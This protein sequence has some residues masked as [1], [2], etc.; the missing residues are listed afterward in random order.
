MKI[1]PTFINCSSN[2]IF[3]LLS[4]LAVAF[5]S[6]NSAN[7]TNEVAAV[8]SAQ[9]TNARKNVK[10]PDFDSDSAYAFTKKQVD[11]GPRVP[12]TSAHAKCADYLANKL[13]TYGL[14]VQVQHATIKTYDGKQFDMKN[15]IGS[16][17]PN[18]SHRIF[19]S[20]HWD[21]RPFADD[22]TVERDK[23]IDAAIDGASGVAVA[24][25]VARNLAQGHPEIGVD[26]ILF[27]LEDY[28]N[29]SGMNT[30]CLGSQY[31]AQNPHKTGYT[32]EFGV[33][34]DMVGAPNA[35]F[36]KESNS[37]T[38]AATFVNKVWN[39]ASN[40]GYGN[41]FVN[42]DANFV[43]IDD[44]IPVN[45]A[46]IPCIDIIQYDRTTQ[47]FA[48]YH[49]THQDNMSLVNRQTLKAVGQTLL[50]VIFKEK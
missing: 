39:A 6:C 48:P 22:D 34:L 43:G 44:H 8:K 11:F 17:N 20:S 12:G 19:V 49:H 18:A 46:G 45:K 7:P 25:E 32:A 28:G 14:E 1:K 4:F 36:P 2:P 24:I 9:D 47:A 40:L 21:A 13:K 15:I 41:Y 37:V 3:L 38:Y 31:W 26:I 42:E 35:I 16:Y 33:L 29:S 50:E 23:P 5:F 10:V 30:W 27:D